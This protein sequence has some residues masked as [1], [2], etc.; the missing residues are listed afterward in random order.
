MQY[1]VAQGQPAC[2]AMEPVPAGSGAASPASAA[3]L[4]PAKEAAGPGEAAPAVL[5]L[6]PSCFAKTSAG[7]D[8]TVHGLTTEVRNSAS[9]STTTRSG[10]NRTDLPLERLSSTLR[11]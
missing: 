8:G 6:D 9:P 7:M 1:R 4:G 10:R 5:R 11:D 2:G 3:A